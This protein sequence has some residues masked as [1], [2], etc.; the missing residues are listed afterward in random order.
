MKFFAV[1]LL[2][3]SLESE[4]NECARDAK[5]YCS[6]IEPGKGQLARCLS[7]YMDQLTPACAQELKAYKAK[8]GKVNPCFEDLAE[9]C[10]DIPAEPRRLEYCLLRNES[11]LS[12]SCSADFRKK[13]GNLIVRD[14][15]AQDMVNTCY[16]SVSEPEGAMSRCLIKNRNK[17][18]GLCQK[19]VDRKIAEMRKANP[20]FDE[21][22][23]YCPTQLRFHEVHDCMEK[24][25]NVLSPACKKIVQEE[26]KREQ[27][28]PCYADLR[29]HCRPGLS[30]SEQ[31]QCLTLN[32]KHL[33]SACRQFR[34]QESDKIKK[35][36]ELCE[37]DR[38]KLCPKAPFQNGMV[39]KCLKENKANVSPGCKALIQ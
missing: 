12:Q 31:H 22:E 6:G 38:L 7:D 25:V 15:C 32:E 27:S 16:A 3:L 19:N 4:A 9:F 30:A 34:V 37:G 20:C 5:K 35:M 36:V 26:I 14:V 24:K 1:L 2:L 18:A 33:S 28:N 8:T 13:K 21:T 29:Q 10:A 17:L 39:L 11:R 23:K